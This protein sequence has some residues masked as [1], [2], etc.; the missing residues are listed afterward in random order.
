MLLLINIFNVDF[1]NKLQ[2]IGNFLDFFEEV[3]I[4]YRCNFNIVYKKVIIREVKIS[5]IF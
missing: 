1:I 3:Y 4:Y 5:E 2:V